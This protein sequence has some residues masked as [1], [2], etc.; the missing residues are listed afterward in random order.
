[1]E[2]ELGFSCGQSLG[3]EASVLWEV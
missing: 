1:M 2:A 3:N